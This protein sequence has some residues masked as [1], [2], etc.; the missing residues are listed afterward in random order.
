M[1]RVNPHLLLQH[2]LVQAQNKV[3][4][5]KQL[6]MT[7][8]MFKMSQVELAKHLETD[9]GTVSEI[10][11]GRRNAST[12]NINRYAEAFGLQVVLVPRILLPFVVTL[13]KRAYTPPV[14][15]VGKKKG[16]KKK[17]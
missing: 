14:K 13:V 6:L 10:E 11:S 16:A 7:R 12:K 2:L 3:S 9:Q 15:E 4:V 17:S 8:T 5:F 1:E